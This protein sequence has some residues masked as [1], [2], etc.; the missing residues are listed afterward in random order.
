[1]NSKQ[2]KKTAYFSKLKSRGRLCRMNI[3]IYI[4]INQAHH[5]AFSK[6]QLLVVSA[7]W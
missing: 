7:L 2:T 4:Y 3:Y 6:A 1:M 5:N